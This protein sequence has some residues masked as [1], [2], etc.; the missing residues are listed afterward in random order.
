M[1]VEA[2]NLSR[3]KLVEVDVE[4]LKIDNN[5]NCWVDHISGYMVSQH[6]LENLISFE[7]AE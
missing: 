3:F 1:H 4:P 6:F 5:A 7:Y 2:S